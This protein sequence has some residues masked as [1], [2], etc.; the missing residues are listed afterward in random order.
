M[1]LAS[2][3]FGKQV[4]IGYSSFRVALKDGRTFVDKSLLILEVIDA[5]PKVILILS[6]PIWK[7]NASVHAQGV[8]HLEAN[9]SLF[10]NLLVK[11]MDPALFDAKGPFG[12]DLA[13][14]ALD[15]DEN[16]LFRRIKSNDDYVNVANLQ[17]SL[18]WLTQFLTRHH[19]EP[20]VVLV[21]EYDYPLACAQSA[22][23][24]SDL[25]ADHVPP[26]EFFRSARGFFGGLFS[27]LLKGNND[28]LFKAVLVGVILSKPDF[29]SGL[30]NIGVHTLADH[31]FSDKFGFTEKEV[32]LSLQQH[33]PRLDQTKV[34]SLYGGCQTVDGLSLYNPWS[35]ISEAQARLKRAGH[36]FVVKRQME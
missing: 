24:E 16:A 2:V 18:K 22:L 26:G 36:K 34:K 27:A 31:E 21:D 23:L 25:S 1:P 5:A 10:E 19:G 15:D 8:V 9:L 20:C 12:I 13:S 35:I 17:F 3:R 11:Q 33:Q 28:N 29:L 4:P 7:F 32:E 6:S 14:D 30:N